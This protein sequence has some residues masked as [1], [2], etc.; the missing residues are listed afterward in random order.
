MTPDRPAPAPNTDVAQAAVPAQPAIPLLRTTLTRRSASVP[1]AE[2]AQTA[3]AARDF[4][5]SYGGAALTLK[6]ITLEVP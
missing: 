4:R 3:I 1:P 6:G 2:P 5:F